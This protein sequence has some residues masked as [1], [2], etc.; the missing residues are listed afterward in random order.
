[1]KVKVGDL[2]ED[3]GDGD[4]GLVVGFLDRWSEPEGF[5][6][7]GAEPLKVALVLWAWSRRPT[8]MDTTAIDS[9]WVRIIS[10]NA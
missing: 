5:V 3:A 10:R 7:A 2:L 6:L 1:M 9:G 4:I 8:E